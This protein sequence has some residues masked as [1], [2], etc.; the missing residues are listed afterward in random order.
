MEKTTIERLNELTRLTGYHTWER[1]TKRCFGKYRGTADYGILLD[2]KTY[3]FISNGMKYFEAS[4]ERFIR[5]IETIRNNRKKY[6]QILKTQLEK[7]NRVALSENLKT[8]EI[9]DVGIE[10]QYEYNMLW[11]YV[12]LRVDRLEFKFIESGLHNDL[13]MDRMDEWLEICNRPVF[14]AGAIQ[15]PDFVFG[16]VRYSST[17]ELYKIPEI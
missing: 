17:E 3:L 8:A 11:S 1:T 5:D 16:N 9:L 14:T 10:T 7:D 12:R 15:K 2:G 6:M 13:T 4:V